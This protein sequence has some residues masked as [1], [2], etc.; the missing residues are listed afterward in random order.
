MWGNDKSF[1]D[2]LSMAS[3]SSDSYA[4]QTFI[5]AFKERYNK[6]EVNGF[7]WAAPQYDFS[8]QQQIGRAHV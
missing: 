4:L 3:G 6:L 1:F 5:E 2:V 8:F 7:G